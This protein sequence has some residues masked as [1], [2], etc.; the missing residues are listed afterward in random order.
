MS[1]PLVDGCSDWGCAL[2][3]DDWILGC[4]PPEQLEFPGAVQ[5]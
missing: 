4:E 5:G 2:K 3:W 1:K